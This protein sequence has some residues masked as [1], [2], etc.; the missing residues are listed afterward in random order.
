MAHH[1]GYATTKCGDKCGSLHTDG[2]PAVFLGQMILE[3]SQSGIYAPNLALSSSQDISWDHL[4][5]IDDGA[6]W[7]LHGPW[8]GLVLSPPRLVLALQCASCS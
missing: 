2:E 4:I 6:P 7:L 1:L 8:V 5:T 3:L